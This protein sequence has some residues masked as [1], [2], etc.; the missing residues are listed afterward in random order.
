M[1]NC[2][3][4]CVA[5]TCLLQK[6]Y[7]Q[8]LTQWESGTRDTVLGLIEA[9]HIK[10]VLFAV[11]DTVI[12]ADRLSEGCLFVHKTNSFGN[13]F[14]YGCYGWQNGIIERV[15]G[16][17]SV[18]SQQLP[19]NTKSSHG[20]DKVFYVQ[21]VGGGSQQTAYQLP[22]TRFIVRNRLFSPLDTISIEEDQAFWDAR[23]PITWDT[24]V[25][26]THEFALMIHNGELYIV[27]IVVYRD[28]FETSTGLLPIQ[29]QAI[30]V[31]R[32]NESIDNCEIVDILELDLN[33]D[34]SAVQ[35]VEGNDP[36]HTNELRARS[37]DNG[38]R[39]TIS[40]RGSSTMY[41]ADLVDDAFTGINFIIGNTFPTD[42]TELPFLGNLDEFPLF[43]QHGSEYIPDPENPERGYYYSYNNGCFPERC[44]GYA[45]QT[46]W[47]AASVTGD[48]LLEDVGTKP[49]FSADTGEPVYSSC[50]GGVEEVLMRDGEL[51]ILAMERGLTG[52]LDSE[53]DFVPQMTNGVVEPFITLAVPPPFSGSSEWQVLVQV[54]TPDGFSVQTSQGGTTT[55]WY[56]DLPTART[57]PVPFWY[58]NG[59][60]LVTQPGARETFW[61]FQGDKVQLVDTVVL[62]GEWTAGELEAELVAFIDD[63]IFMWPIIGGYEFDPSLATTV[64]EAEAVT[65]QVFPNPATHTVQISGLHPNTEFFIS[66]IISQNVLT[67]HTDGVIDVSTLPP[68][69]YIVQTE[70]GNARFIKE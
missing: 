38:I 15:G 70:H 10:N 58:Q 64:S 57:E 41:E 53:G 20:D 6:S 26:D 44:P 40:N 65:L 50:C 24:T 52:I 56:D 47:F 23:Y 45:Q 3:L 49:I 27:T 21:M 62:A 7:G 43:N 60:T 4:L 39:I 54:F 8:E 16:Y 51:P 63:S 46:S 55:I 66:N 68:G 19:F 2:I 12:L 11:Q 29:R 9:E 14:V 61:E 36:S 67:G 37:I 28:Y 59:N 1:K 35:I 42:G 13:K 34:E 32:Y 30:V 22:G 17:R 25:F 69:Y 31:Y 33:W 5:L 48:T 18:L